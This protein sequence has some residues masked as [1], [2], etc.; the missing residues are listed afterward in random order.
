MDGSAVTAIVFIGG[1]LQSKVVRWLVCAATVF[2]MVL[3][4]QISP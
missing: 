4:V 3:C 1:D 2:E